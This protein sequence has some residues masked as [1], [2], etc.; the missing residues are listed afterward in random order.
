MPFNVIHGH[1]LR[2][3][4]KPIATNSGL[5]GRMGRYRQRPKE[6]K[7]AVF[8]DATHLTR[9]P[10]PANI[11]INLTCIINLKKQ[12]PQPPLGACKAARP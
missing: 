11:H 6:A 4:E 8:D 1:L 10:P 7:I 5:V 3:N 2:C 12:R 9:M